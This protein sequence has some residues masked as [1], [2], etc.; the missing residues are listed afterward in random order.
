MNIR[1]TIFVSQEVLAKF[2]STEYSAK[3]LTNLLEVCAAVKV[4]EL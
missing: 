2:L 1:A 3:K 4:F